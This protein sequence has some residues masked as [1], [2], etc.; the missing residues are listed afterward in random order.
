MVSLQVPT[1]TT[2]KELIIIV[3]GQKTYQFIRENLCNQVNKKI[4]LKKM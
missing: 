1:S 2:N 4:I 3:I